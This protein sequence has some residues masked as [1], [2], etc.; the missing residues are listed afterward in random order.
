MTEQYLF[1]EKT[2]TML[3]A[4]I[5]NTPVWRVLLYKTQQDIF[6]EVTIDPA[7]P[8]SHFTINAVYIDGI[9]YTPRSLAQLPTNSKSWAQVDELLYINYADTFPAWMFVSHALGTVIGR[10]TGKTRFFDGYKF[11]AG[12]S[13]KLTYT[14]EADNLEYSKM[15]LIGG[16]YEIENLG[17]FDSLT[18]ILG[19]NIETSFSLD[20]ITRTSLNTMF[21]ESA[22]ITLNKIAI[23]AADKREKLNVS[24]A[25]EI[26]TEEEYPKM[27]EEHY[28]KNKQEAFG[29][30]RDVP[31]VCLDNRDVYDAEGTN[32]N[33]YRTFRVASVITSIAKIEVKMTQPQ[34]GQNKGGDVWVDQTA[35]HTAIGDGMINLPASIC[36]P[37][38]SNGEPD[39]GNEPY[40]VRVTG[41]FRDDGSHEAILTDLL[42]TALGDTWTDQCWVTEIQTELSGTGKVGLFI[43]KET[44][45]FDIIQTLQSSGIYGWQLHDY[46]GRL[47]V[48]KDDNN[49]SLSGK[50]V[51]G[52]D[53]INSNSIAVRLGMD[54]YAT[55]I[56][57]EYQHS[58]SEASHSEESHNSILDTSNRAVLFPIYRNDKTYT[59]KSYLETEADAQAACAY[60]KRHFEIPRL[61][62]RNIQLAGPQWLDLRIYDIIGVYL[63]QTIKTVQL[64]SSIMV[65]ANEIERIPYTTTGK[66]S[67]GGNCY[68]KIMRIAIDITSLITTIDG[69][70]IKPIGA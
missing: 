24:I 57:V 70:Y 56:K 59:K 42:E 33:E 17:E 43:E 45:I 15:K 12:M 62:I 63:E 60:L 68:I 36:L 19:N 50:K 29:Y 39:Y 53:I 10:S 69:L 66:R 49:R 7:L 58:Y 61:E 11:S 4:C 3:P 44:K 13:V 64:P 1:I 22:E 65:L 35:S 18:D 28:G 37:I 21:V 41:L 23:Q 25:G 5:Q 38:L 14:I 67:F 20:G 27:K 52:I 48:R 55:T 40:E 2:R 46:Q 51:R 9:E 30:C 31:A 6:D 34:D 26:F 54:N 8:D 16:N 47:T 32:Y